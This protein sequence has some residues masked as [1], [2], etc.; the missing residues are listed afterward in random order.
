MGCVY[1]LRGAQDIDKKYR[2]ALFD[3]LG[4]YSGPHH[5]ILFASQEDAMHYFSAQ[6]VVSIPGVISAQ[7]IGALALWLKKKT[8]PQMQKYLQSLCAMYDTISLDQACMIVAYMQV[9]GKQEDCTYIFERILE[10]EKSLFTLSQ[11]F[12]AKDSASFFKLWARFEAEYPIT[13]W[14]TYWSEQLWRAYHARYFL[15][16]NQMAQAKTVGAR[17]PFSYLQRDWKKSTR[18]ELK[19]AHQS[20]YELDNASKNTIE[21]Q[22]GIDLFYTKFFLNELKK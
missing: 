1:L 20:I 11:Y 15:E 21:T 18:V 19:Q 14:C 13:F 7:L 9:I 6:L 22:V 17:L 16:K 4:T 3:Y 10:S 12:F 5:V 2:Q 8:T